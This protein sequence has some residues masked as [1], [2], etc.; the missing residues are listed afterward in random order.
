[1]NPGPARGPGPAARLVPGSFFGQVG[2]QKQI[3][4][5]TLSVVSHAQSRRVP[6]HSH[7]HAFLTVLLRGGYHEDVHGQRVVHG[8]LSVVFHPEGL[9]HRDE[10]AE[11]G[12]PCP[13]GASPVRP[14]STPFTSRGSTASAAADPCANP[15]TASG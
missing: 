10:I 3:D 13:S 14:V 2:L 15:S 1:M 6:E 9:V 7:E 11:G 12:S 8:A 5:V 4:L